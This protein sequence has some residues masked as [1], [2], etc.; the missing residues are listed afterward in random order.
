MIG[1]DYREG[2]IILLMLLSV[3]PNALL[4]YF[5]NDEGKD[6]KTSLKI[7]FR[8]LTNQEMQEEEQQ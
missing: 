1:I 4:L 2:V 3:V 6:V 5:V 7:V 8:L